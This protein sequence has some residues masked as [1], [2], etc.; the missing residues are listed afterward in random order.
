[1]FVVCI[2]LYLYLHLHLYV[3]VYVDVDVTYLSAAVLGPW[4]LSRKMLANEIARRL[5][6]EVVVAQAGC[7]MPRAPVATTSWLHGLTRTPQRQDAQLEL[8]W[9]QS[10]RALEVLQVQQASQDEVRFH[11]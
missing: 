11:S 7:L 1:M 4:F 9:P 3:N 2:Y 8:S 10:R 6:S 5:S